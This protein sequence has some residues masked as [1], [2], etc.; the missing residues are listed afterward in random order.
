MTLLLGSLAESRWPSD[1]N[2]MPSLSHVLPFKMTAHG[3]K[4]HLN[5]RQLLPGKKEKLSLM[6]WSWFGHP[7]PPG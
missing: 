5:L 1:P 7:E 4:L 6:G 3:S 2:G